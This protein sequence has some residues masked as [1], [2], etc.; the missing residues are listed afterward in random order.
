MNKK[1]RSM[2]YLMWQSQKVMIVGLV[3][4]LVYTIFLGA[5]NFDLNIISVL[6]YWYFM[7]GCVVILSY[8][9]SLSKTVIPLSIAMGAARKETVAGIMITNLIMMVE[10]GAMYIVAD[11]LVNREIEGRI[12]IF[13]AVVTLIIL[14]GALSNVLTV[15][16]ANTSNMVLVVIL[17]AAMVF[18]CGAVVGFF[19][20]FTDGNGIDINLKIKAPVAI[21][22][23]IVSVAVYGI[24][25]GYFSKKMKKY[26]VSF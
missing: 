26:K 17:T 10:I 22:A 23:I 13:L 8:A 20:S 11:V 18:I 5:V 24:S 16:F 7:F 12:G 9:F 21:L 14:V 6:P 3:A 19:V 15:F 4:P 1:N 2:K 25:A